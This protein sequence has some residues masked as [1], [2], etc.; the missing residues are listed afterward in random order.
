MLYYRNLRKYKY[1]TLKDVTVKIRI[2]PPYNILTS[3][4]CLSDIGILTIYKGYAWDGA[5]GPTWDDKTN[6]GSSLVH[7]VLYQLIREGYLC[8]SDREE[9][10][11]ELRDISIKNG[12]NRFRAWYWYQA[13]RRFARFAAR[14]TYEPQDKVC[15][16]PLEL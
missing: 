8:G 4:C 1:E 15:T 6:K 11:K 5:S 12:M 3:Y 7:D 9:A 16:A 10:D 2:K 14:K 13:V